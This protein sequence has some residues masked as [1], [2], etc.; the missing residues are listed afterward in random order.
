M[1]SAQHT[2]KKI[3][4][5]IGKGLAA[6]L[7]LVIVLY[8]ALFIYFKAN[9][10]KIIAEVHKEIREK[11]KGNIQI[12]DI[13][14]GVFRHFPNTTVVLKDILITDSLFSIHKTPLLKARLAG[15]EINIWK[16]LFKDDPI[17]GISVEDGQVNLFTDSTGYT[18]QY[19]LTPKQR[20]LPGDK[21]ESSGNMIEDI[22]LDNMRLKMENRIKEKLYDIEAISLKCSIETND[23]ALHFNTKNDLLIHTVTFNA[24]KGGFMQEASF[25]GSFPVTFNKV[26][27][28]IIFKN[29]SI[30]LKNHPFLFS[31]KFSTTGSKPYTIIVSTKKILYDL[32]KSL[33][34][35]KVNNSLSIVE[36]EKP[37]DVKA[38]IMGYL[39]PGSPLVKVEWNTTQPNYI[40]TPFAEIENATFSGSYTNQ[41]IV[42]KERNDANSQLVFNNFT[43]Y[44]EGIK[45]LSDKIVIDN[46]SD[47]I[48]SGDFSSD[49]KLADFNNLL[50][51]SSITMTKGMGKLRIRYTGPLSINVNEGT[52]IT[53]ALLI[54]DGE[55]YYHPRDIA[56]QQCNGKIIFGNTDVKLQDFRCNVLNTKL[57]LN[58]HAHNL[59]TLMNTNPGQIKLDCNIYTPSLKLEN[60]TRL[61]KQRNKVLKK[62]VKGGALQNVAVKVDEML[63]K[64]AVAMQLKTPELT[65]KKFAA[66]DLDA[67]ISLEQDNWELENISLMHGSGYMKIKGKLQETDNRYSKADLQVNMD[68]VDI[69]KLFY[70]FENFGQDAIHSENVQGILKTDVDVTMKIDRELQ[71]SPTEINGFVDFSLKKGA[72]LNFEPIQK[73]QT[74]LFKNRNFEQLYFAE[75]KNRFEIKGR[76]IKINRMAISSTALHLF[77]EGIYSLDEKTDLLIQVP[78]KN[79]KKQKEDFKLPEMENDARGGMS[80]FLRGKPGNDGKIEFKVDVLNKVRKKQ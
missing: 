38:T 1:Q 13:D 56:M 66:K 59:I 34:P 33:L 9:K 45:I 47:P 2:L 4:K 70:A 36:I 48:L 52:K 6:V 80:V 46:L 16:A 69:N 11:V 8:A 22:R 14:V 40:S 17:T 41:V 65:F 15:I 42:G 12:G 77:V 60:F 3:A 18:N 72:L 7:L 71:T 58:A 78:L 43:G 19:I 32:G 20:S 53:G 50:Q 27:K 30:K 21:K 74:F 68:N 54:Q 73:L 5:N 51:S 63:D 55:V 24:Q 67:A 75:I 64:S 35:Q 61:L 37:I 29:N 79:L 25:K 62:N 57:V 26:T 31:G 76:E 23:T 49:F 39:K 44:W 28:Q 10:K